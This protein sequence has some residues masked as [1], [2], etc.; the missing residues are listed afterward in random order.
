LPSNACRTI[1]SIRSPSVMSYRSA[2]A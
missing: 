1:P 2:R